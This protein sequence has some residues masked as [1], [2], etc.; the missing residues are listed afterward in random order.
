MTTRARVWPLPTSPGARP[1]ATYRVRVLGTPVFVEAFADVGY[2]RFA[3]RGQVKVQIEAA[4]PI[5]RVAVFPPERA[6]SPAVDGNVLTLE[7][8]APDSLVVR[9]DDCRRSSCS[10]STRIPTRRGGPGVI[11][12]AAFGADVTGG[13]VATRDLQ[14]AIRAAALRGGGTVLLPRGLFRTGTLRLPSHVTL[15]LAPGALLQGS[16]D[17]ADYPLDPGREERG[18]DASLPPDARFDGRSMTFSRLLLV[19]RAED[20]RIA[21]RGTID[22]A[23]R[24]LRTQRNAVPNL[25]RVRESSGVTIR[26]VLFR[27]AAAWSLH[28]LASSDVHVG[29]VKI[30]NDRAV[31][32]TDGIDPD[33]S[34]DVT[35][36]R[37]FIYTKDDA[38]CVKATGNG[39]LSG[40]V[41]RIRVTN[42]L[43]SAVD[44]GLKVGTES[45]AAR[46]AD[47]RFEDNHVFESGRAMSVVVRDGAMYERLAFRR[48]AVGPD[49]QHL[50]EQVIG[51][52][53]P[54]ARLGVIRDLA[55]EDVSAPDHRPPASN[56]TWYAQFRPGRPEPG[57]PVPVF[58]GA[59]DVHAVDG[60]TLRDVVVDGRALVDDAT[61]AEVA[62]LTIGAHVRG[63]SVE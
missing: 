4:R 15:Y 62:G 56:W 27:D 58:E 18:V 8:Q 20:V 12:A 3:M 42:N 50:V 9:L 61:A 26:D 55:F 57:T 10:R 39:G 40:D 45:R 49:V 35:I 37:S 19:D 51:V 30:V 54:E 2:A 52:R 46:V 17:P 5:D 44:A 38:I 24:V 23:G 25:L 13:T 28:L 41:E 31:P 36:D 43:V 32:N 21:G 16:D 60:L 53:D 14:A 59:D 1:S 33:M 34:T 47:V 7:L 11:D 29:N 63:V 48:I 6:S 22:G